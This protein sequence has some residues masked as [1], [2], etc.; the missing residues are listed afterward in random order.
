[1]RVPARFTKCVNCGRL[2]VV[3]GTNP[4]GRCTKDCVTTPVAKT[5]SL[6]KGD[7]K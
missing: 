7:R 4:T 2:I 1:M 5:V 6:K 3:D